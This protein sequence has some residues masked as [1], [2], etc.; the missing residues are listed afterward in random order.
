MKM[1]IYINK[2]KIMSINTDRIRNI[3]YNEYNRC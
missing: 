2:V 3:L 1:E